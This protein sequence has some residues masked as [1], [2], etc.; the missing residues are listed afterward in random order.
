LPVCRFPM[1]GQVFREGQGL[2]YQ[3][4]V[5]QPGRQVTRWKLYLS[6]YTSFIFLTKVIITKGKRKFIL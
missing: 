1:Y 2:A 6:T 3:T 5:E 4:T